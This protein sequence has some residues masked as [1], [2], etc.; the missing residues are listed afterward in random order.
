MEQDPGKDEGPPVDEDNDLFN[1]ATEDEHEQ[2]EGFVVPK[3]QKQIISRL[4]ARKQKEAEA[5]ANFKRAREV[6]PDELSDEDKEANQQLI[7]DRKQDLLKA[8]KQARASG[9]NVASSRGSVAS[10]YI[11]AL[12]SK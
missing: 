6:E 4:R 8:A 11:E 5:D 9:S 7:H 3:A 2:S 12:S 1:N 10:A